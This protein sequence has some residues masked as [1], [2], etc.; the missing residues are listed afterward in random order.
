MKNKPIYVEIPIQATL[1]E[2]W[3]MTQKPE[4]HEQ[5]DLRFS[6]ITY[7]PKKSE[8]DRH[9]FLYET[10]LGR[11]VKVAGWGKSV[12]THNKKDGSKTSSLHFGT[13]QNISPIREGKGYWQYIPTDNG[14]TF[15]TQYDYDVRY[16]LLGKLLDLFFRPLM[17]WATALSFDVLKRWIE[18]GESPR[19]QYV[20]FI[21]NAIVTMLFV[22]VWLY[23]GLI[24]K[25]IAK[26]PEEV[27]MLS[28][29][30]SLDGTA[31]VK[32][33]E[34]IGVLEILFA[35]VWLLY[36]KKRHLLI[37]QII[38]FPLLTISALIASPSLASHPFTPI[39]FN[40]SL[41]VLSIVS[42]LLATDLPSATSCRR[43][44]KGES[45]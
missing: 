40:A 32:G 25:M 14:T 3:R 10:K 31:A 45:S 7:L 41:W 8:D 24:P 2:V 23:H 5:W 17:G 35:V 16:G 27:S 38:I 15:L 22:F 36:R 42:F 4:L 37:L 28:S 30:T 19:S 33:V 13:D 29:L 6:S 20:R 12:G 43:T 9:S 44:R 34:I 39:T 26:H 21:I 11:Y 18:K 1:D